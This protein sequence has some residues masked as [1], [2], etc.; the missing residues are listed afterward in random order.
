MLNNSLHQEAI[1]VLANP[2]HFQSRLYQPITLWNEEAVAFIKKL[3]LI[4]YPKHHS[5]EIYDETAGFV[6]INEYSLYDT[7][8]SSEKLHF[9][10]TKSYAKL[11]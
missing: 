9:T 3:N 10:C 11:P 2:P 6:I 5:D 7:S 4:D 8:P 1:I